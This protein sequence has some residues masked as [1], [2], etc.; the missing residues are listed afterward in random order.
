MGRRAEQT[1]PTLGP[2]ALLGLFGAAQTIGGMEH[3]A[4]EGLLY[5]NLHTKAH[6]YYGEMRGQ[7]YPAVQ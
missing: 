5:F 1:L 7:I 4:R 6:T 3:I 2:G